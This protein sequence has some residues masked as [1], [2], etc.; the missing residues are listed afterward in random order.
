MH[1]G[2][3]RTEL[4]TSHHALRTAMTPTRFEAGR[5]MM[6]AGT[7]RRH[8]FT[9]AARGTEDQ[10]RDF[11][12][13]TMLP[14]ATGEYRFG[15]LC[16][17]DATGLEYMTA[18]EVESFAGLP[19]GTGRMRV[20]PQRYAIFALPDGATI[21]STWRQ[22]FAWLEG[23]EY[24]SAHLPDFERYPADSDPRAPGAGVE[25]WV[26]VVARS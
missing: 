13:N 6:L 25:F 17:A 20:P 26:G 3:P 23:G 7:R 19:E 5:P 14:G 18:V 8:D 24:Q 11:L 22:I 2:A 4:R 15:V 12:A 1:V 9:N 10:W 16:G 21:E